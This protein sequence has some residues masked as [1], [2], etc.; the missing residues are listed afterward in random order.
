MKHYFA[1]IMAAMGQ[2]RWF[3]ES[4]YPRYVKFSPD[5][6]EN[7]YASECLLMEIACQGCG[8]IFRVSLNSGLMEETSL[9]DIINEYKYIHYGDP[10]NMAC[11]LAGPTMNCIDLRIIEFW[12]RDGGEWARV[13]ELE[14]ELEDEW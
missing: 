12:Q 5:E 2:P 4:G 10:P 13:P 3:T 7:I 9:S 8:K 11:C 14:I 6:C 1:E